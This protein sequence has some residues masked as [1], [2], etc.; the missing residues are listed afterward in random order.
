MDFQ[1]HPY[2]VVLLISALTT[3]VTSIIVLRREVPGAF[4]LGGVLISTFI[5]SGAYALSWSL[6]ALAEKLIWIKIT[7]LGVIAAPTLFLLFTLHSSPWPWPGSGQTLS[8]GSL[9]SNNATALRCYILVAG[10]GSG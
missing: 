1:F 5:W 4:L 2:A 10:W 7:Y 3:L 6:V 9:S 8:S